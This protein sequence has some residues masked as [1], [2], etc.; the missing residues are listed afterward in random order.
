[1]N[2][3]EMLGRIEAERIDFIYLL[4][5]DITGESK[6][7]TIQ[8]SM[9]DSALKHGIWFDGSSI[10][11]FARLCESDMLLKLD[12]DTFS[13]LPWTEKNGRSAQIICDVYLPSEQPFEGDP[14]GVLKR[15]LKRAEEMGL[16][17]YVGP[18]IE[19]F[20]FE[21]DALPELKPHDNK[22]YF[23]LGVQSRAVEICQE[24]MRQMD[25]FGVHC[26]TYHHEVSE[27]QHEIDLTYDKA[28]KIADAILSLKNALR[29]Y[30]MTADLKVS[31]MA[32]PIFGVNGNGMHIHQS[33]G[34]DRGKNLFYN[35]DDPYN[36][37][38][39]AYHFLAGQIEHAKALVSLVAP[40]VNSYKRLVPGYEA[41]VYICWGRTNRSALIRVPRV[42]E[43]KAREGARLELRCPDPS[44][45]PYLAL[46]GMLQAGLDGIEQ[47]LTPGDS[48]EENVFDF[49]HSMLKEKDISVLPSNIGDA[50]DELEQD[51]VLCEML[52]KGLTSHFIQAKRQEWREFLMQVTPWEI[53]R[54]L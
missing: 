51:A 52:G 28:L 5:T 48:V 31:F 33:L 41:P 42:T 47:K 25:H 7:V 18:E 38:R 30:S 15:T 37:S 46:A 21:R 19:F 45:N 14:R 13:I 2:E 3:K 20:L 43:T 17:Y 44:C 24:T 29:T 26:E 12:V 23:D 27:G 36:I 6:K 40:T 49:S 10:E 4:F 11:G 39:L 54:Y 34:D 53:E 9:V 35:A 50:V 22:G 32:K 8:A 16:T 1:M